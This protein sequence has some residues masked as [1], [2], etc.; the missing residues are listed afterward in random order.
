MNSCKYRARV[1]YWL[2]LLGLDLE[3]NP[4]KIGRLEKS[5]AQGNWRS[6]QSVNTREQ[7]NIIVEC[8]ESNDFFFAHLCAINP[9]LVLFLSVDLLRAF[10][11]DACLGKAQEIL[12]QADQPQFQTRNIILSGKQ[13]PRLKVGMQFFRK[14]TVVALPHPAYRG[15]IADEYIASFSEWIG[16]ELKLYMTA[17]RESRA[18]R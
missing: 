11:A 7:S 6:T 3:T 12:G 18:Y 17:Q 15:G 14:T 16:N 2:K 4:K 5:T 13:H 1:L 8:I 10:N 9:S